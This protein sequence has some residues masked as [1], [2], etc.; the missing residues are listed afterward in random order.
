M[1]PLNVCRI[2]GTLVAAVL[3]RPSVPSLAP[4]AAAARGGKVRGGKNVIGIDGSVKDTPGG[5]L[6][7]GV[8]TGGSPSTQDEFLS[9]G[10]TDNVVARA[11]DGV[12]LFMRAGIRLFADAKAD[13][14]LDL[15]VGDLGFGGSPESGSFR[16]VNVVYRSQGD[17]TTWP[18]AAAST[19]T[20]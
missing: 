5:K 14:A 16:Q 7:N 10:G 13:C 18:K 6:E 9:G 11:P 8:C 19:V 1:S 3:A 20:E 15:R 2:A 17:G 12:L 4:P